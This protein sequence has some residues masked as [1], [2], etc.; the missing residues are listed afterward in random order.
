MCGV[1]AVARFRLCLKSARCEPEL[2]SPL[3]RELTRSC[4]ENSISVTRVANMSSAA[5]CFSDVSQKVKNCDTLWP[6]V[7]TGDMS[8]AS[9]CSKNIQDDQ[10]R[11]HDR[12]VAAMAG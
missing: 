4:R 10:D 12:T 1:R 2:K 8:K 3:I 6:H 7:Y 9:L 11:I 5:T